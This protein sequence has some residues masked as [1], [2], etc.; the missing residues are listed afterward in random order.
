[1]RLPELGV[2]C[3]AELELELELEL[4]SAAHGERAAVLLQ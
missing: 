2:Q 4:V 3:S 1:M